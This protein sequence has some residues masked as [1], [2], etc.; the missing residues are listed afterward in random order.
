MKEQLLTNIDSFDYY[1]FR[2]IKLNNIQPP[3]NNSYVSIVEIEVVNRYSGINY[4][5]RNGSLATASSYYSGALADGVPQT[6]QQAI[7]GYIDSQTNHRWTNDERVSLNVLGIWFK[8][9]LKGI[10]Q[11]N[12]IRLCSIISDQRCYNFDLLASN[13]DIDYVLI[14]ECRN[15]PFLGSFIFYE[16]LP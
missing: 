9:D 4:C 16:L 13:N 12:S 6:P 5:T 1:Q 15:L 7:D 2:Y 10:R 14:K 8:I 11:F 3:I